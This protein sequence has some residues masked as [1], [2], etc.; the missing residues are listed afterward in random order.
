MLDTGA[1]HSLGDL[2]FQ[3]CEV[4]GSKAGPTGW[5]SNNGFL[6]TPLTRSPEDC[7]CWSSPWNDDRTGACHDF[8]GVFSLPLL[9][10]IGLSQP[11]MVLLL[12]TFGP[13]YFLAFES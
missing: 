8:P 11:L 7:L 5:T 2:R 13:E 9:F 6:F 3:L 12:F 1:N 10:H 4:R